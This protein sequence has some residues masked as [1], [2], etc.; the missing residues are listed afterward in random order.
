[1]KEKEKEKFRAT[2][3]GSAIDP[4]HQGRERERE[5]ERER[6]GRLTL[7]SLLERDSPLSQLV[8]VQ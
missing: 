3:N 8:H 6:M 2:V 1:V 5:R 7:E 4:P